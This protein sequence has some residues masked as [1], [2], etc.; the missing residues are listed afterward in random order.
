MGRSNGTSG[1]K[2]G[3]S[4][5][6]PLSKAPGIQFPCPAAAVPTTAG[7]QMAGYEEHTGMRKTHHS[8]SNPDR[9]EAGEEAKEG[10]MCYGISSKEAMTTVRKM[11]QR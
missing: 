1:A 8:V 11:S 7:S 6:S 10:Q 4:S 3:S 9:G 5:N 2:L